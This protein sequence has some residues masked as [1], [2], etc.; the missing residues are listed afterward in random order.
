MASTTLRVAPRTRTPG[1]LAFA[2]FKLER[3]LREQD[4]APAAAVMIDALK[5][6]IA[7]FEVGRRV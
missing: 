3:M 6:K 1:E 7:A 4:D 5:A 2:R